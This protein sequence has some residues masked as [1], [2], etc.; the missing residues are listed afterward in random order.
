MR[1]NIITYN[2]KV[3][4]GND[5]INSWDLRVKRIAK[6]IRAYNPVVIGTQEGLDYMLNDLKEILPE[7]SWVG[8]GRCG[9]I[10]LDTDE[11]NAIFYK[12]QEVQL[13]E[14][15]QFAL[16]KTP[17]VIGTKDWDCGCPRIC[18]WAHFREIET[19]KEL[20]VYNTHLDHVSEEGRAQG[21]NIV[22]NFMKDK[23]N[24]NKVP[25]MLMGDFNCFTSERTFKIIK[26]IQDENFKLKNC[27]SE[28]E[29]SVTCTFH[30]FKG[31]NNHGVIDYILTS[32]EFKT[33]G[34]EVFEGLIEGGYPSDHYPVIATIEDTKNIEYTKANNSDFSELVDF[35]NN[36]FNINFPELLPK[37]YKEEYKTM[38][39]HYIVK[40]DNE[41]RAA[42]GSFPMEL[43]VLDETLKV[44]GIG[45]VSVHKDAR[46]SGYM[47][48]LM[49]MALEDM[50]KEGV[51]ISCLGGQR[52][53]YEYFSYTP[54][55]QKVNF[56]INETNIRHKF[57]NICEDITFTLVNENDTER[58][59]EIYKLQSEE[60]V[61]VKREKEAFLDILK[62]WKCNAYSI[63]NHNEFIGYIVLSEDKTSIN[64]VILKD[65]SLFAQV[66][67]SHI[68]NN[69]VYEVRISLPLHEQ[70]RIRAMQQICE[71]YSIDNSYQF[72]IL[73]YEKV[74]K[75]LLKLKSTYSKLEDGKL[76]LNIKEY[77]TVSISVCNSEI[78]VNKTEEQV[79]LCLEHLEAMEL[80]FAPL[81]PYLE[82]PE[83]VEKCVQ[84]WLPLPLD[85]CG[86]DHV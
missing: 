52:Q 84:S 20:V 24:E 81:T 76:N 5:E 86:V 35:A 13:L 39:H 9:E 11:Y 1:G 47:K 22:L 50:K 33:S 80:L 65:E 34:I 78:E 2:L 48:K 57:K 10:A 38:P 82:L 46:G 28:V 40:E 12:N 30:D 37:L 18:T 74:I 72:S 66:V 26:D 25:Y 23:Y 51:A 4:S 21:I 15:G 45:T 14:W 69:D 79:D 49:H 67:A 75:A 61:K 68:K 53:R 42:I 55:G 54:C 58:I 16:S 7:Y 17:E 71:S 19:N 70:K 32:K 3:D 59:E 43:D 63:T 36:V 73:D 77:G 6:V 41:I 31:E 83:Q 85:L 60:K 64:E 44:S 29:N 56:T 27:F 62:S 8:A